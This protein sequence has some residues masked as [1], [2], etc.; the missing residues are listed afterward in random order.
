[1]GDYSQSCT[2]YY[3]GNSCSSRVNNND[4]NNCSEE[5]GWT[6]YLDDF[7]NDF[8][9]K[10]GSFFA[11]GCESSCLVSGAACSAIRDGSG[12][13]S[14]CKSRTNLIMERRRS[15]AGIVDKELE[16]TASSPSHSPKLVCDMNQSYMNSNGLDSRD[17][18]QAY[19]SNNFQNHQ[20][21]AYDH[22]PC[23]SQKKRR[24]SQDGVGG[25]E[26]DCMETQLR[27]KGLCLVPMSSMLL[28]YLT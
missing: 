2:S 27:R 3:K 11:S 21:T 18:Y 1:M 14:L 15:K 13:A 8:H 4:N 26:M 10:D 22:S 23:F 19:N 20:Q 12:D 16:D 6:M 17:V 9:L 5:S 28:D 24:K 7:D 25:V